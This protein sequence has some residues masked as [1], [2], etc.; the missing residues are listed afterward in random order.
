MPRCTLLICTL[1]LAG[2][3]NFD[4]AQLGLGNNDGLPPKIEG[5]FELHQVET[6]SG[7]LEAVDVIMGRF[8]GCHWGR[9][10]WEFQGDRVVVGHDLLCPGANDQENFGCSVS[11][12]LEAT[13]NAEQ[14]SW[15]IP[16]GGSATSRTK[17]MDTL[18]L[19]VPTMCS[20]TVPAGNYPVA[21]V[22][23]QQWRWEMGQPDGTVLRLKVADSDRPDFVRALRFKEAAE[24]EAAPAEAPTADKP[25]QEQG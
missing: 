16:L 9:M 21:R 10:T 20:V 2:G 4:L 14:G 19:K 17:G 15:T 23:N 25:G 7:E 12:A 22:R 6:A 18:A 5:L 3:E 8:P 11:L 13:W 1:L 24:A